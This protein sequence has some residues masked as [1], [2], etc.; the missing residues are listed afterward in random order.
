MNE[1]LE[2]RVDGCRFSGSNLIPDSVTLNEE[3]ARRVGEFVE[4]WCY[5]QGIPATV[6]SVWL[7][8]YEGE[9]RVKVNMSQGSHLLFFEED[10]IDDLMDHGS[11]EALRAIESQLA[12]KFPVRD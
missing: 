8:L 10:L 5:R 12:A 6:S 4:D 1:S 11:S 2:I 9:F 7:K 3:R